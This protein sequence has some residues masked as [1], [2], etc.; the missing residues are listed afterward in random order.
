MFTEKQLDE[1]E[2]RR[3]AADIPALVDEVRA[4]NRVVDAAFNLKEVRA[5]MNRHNKNFM[6]IREDLT[7]K[8]EA[9]QSALVKLLEGEEGAGQGE[10][11]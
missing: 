6:E 9:F 4:F 11:L 5:R 10:D 7:E 1:I 8:E 2:A 3:S